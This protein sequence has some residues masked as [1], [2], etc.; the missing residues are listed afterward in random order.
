MKRLEQ[1]TS[2][3][4][5]AE[6]WLSGAGEEESGELLLNVYRGSIWIEEKTGDRQ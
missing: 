1:L 3:K 2:Q 6:W 5:K 4:Q